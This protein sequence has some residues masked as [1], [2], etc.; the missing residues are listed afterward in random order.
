MYFVRSCSTC[1]HFSLCRHYGHKPKMPC[2][3]WEERIVKYEITVDSYETEYYKVIN[4]ILGQMVISK[5]KNW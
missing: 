2:G 1:R 4:P 3:T 5:L